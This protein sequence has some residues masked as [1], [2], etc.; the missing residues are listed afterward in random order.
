TTFGQYRVLGDRREGGFNVVYAAQTAVGNKR[1][2]KFYRPENRP[3]F[4]RE[5]E[6]LKELQEDEQHQNL[7]CLHYFNEENMVPYVVL[8]FCE[9]SFVEYMDNMRKRF[10]PYKLAPAAMGAAQDIVEALIYI[11]QRDIVHCDVKGGNILGQ[12]MKGLGHTWKL[13]DFDSARTVNEPVERTTYCPPEVANNILSGRRVLPGASEK[14]D[15]FGLGCT[16]VESITGNRIVD[17]TSEDGLRKLIDPT[18]D[19]EAIV[20]RSL[21]SPVKRLLRKDS[22]NRVSVAE[23]KALLNRDINSQDLLRAFED[24]QKEAKGQMQSAIDA[25]LNGVNALNIDVSSLKRELGDIRNHVFAVRATVDT[26]RLFVII[27]AETTF[28]ITKI[29]GKKY[30]LHLMC[31]H[32]QHHIADLETGGYEIVDLHR[33]VS[34]ARPWLPYVTMCMRLLTAALPAAGVIPTEISKQVKTVLDHSAQAVED[35]QLMLAKYGDE[36]EVLGTDGKEHRLD[37]GPALRM[38]TAFLTQNDSSKKFDGLIPCDVGGGDVRWM[39]SAHATLYNR[40]GSHFD[41]SIPNSNQHNHQHFPS[42]P[43]TPPSPPPKTSFAPSLSHLIQR[44]LSDVLN[45][46]TNAAK[47]FPSGSSRWHV[48]FALG[49]RGIPSAKERSVRER[50]SIP[51]HENVLL[52]YN[53]PVVVMRYRDN[54]AFGQDKL[55]WF[56]RYAS[57]ALDYKD[58]AQV[59][60]NINRPFLLAS[61]GRAALRCSHP[62]A[63]L[64]LLNAVEEIVLK[65]VNNKTGKKTDNASPDKPNEPASAPRTENNA[66]RPPMPPPKH[67]KPSFS[68]PPRSGSLGAMENT[69]DNRISVGI[70]IDLGTS[71]SFL[72][73]GKT[74]V[75]DE[76]QRYTSRNPQNTIFGVKRLFGREFDDVEVQYM[77]R[78]WPFTLVGIDGQP[79]IQIETESGDKHHYK[80]EEISALILL[81]LKRQAEIYLGDGFKVGGAVITVPAYFTDAQRQATKDAASIAGLNVLRMTSEATAASMTYGIHKFLDQVV[82]VVVIDLGG[83]TSDISLI[84]VE[85]NLFEV[86]HTMA[87]MQLGGEDFTDRLVEHCVA[88]FAKKYGTRDIKKSPK[89]MQRL[90]TECRAAQS[91]L[92]AA[93]TAYIQLD[94]LYDGLDLYTTISRQTFETVCQVLFTKIGELLQD[95]ERALK[96]YPVDTDGSE[97]HVVLVGGATRIP[98]IRQMVSDVFGQNVVSLGINPDEAVAIGAA[99]FAAI[100]SGTEDESLCDVL[101]LDVTPFSL[102]V[103]TAGNE[104]AISTLVKQDSSI[105]TK[106][107]ILFTTCT[108]D[109]SE[110]IIPI[111]ELSGRKGSGK[112]GNSFLGCLQLTGLQAA[113]RGVP[114]IEVVFDIDANS[115]LNVTATELSSGKQ[116]AMCVTSD[117]S[118]HVNS[119]RAKSTKMRSSVVEFVGPESKEGEQN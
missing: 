113:P 52:I 4:T 24:G 85:D 44:V 89:A 20:P 36:A 115:I 27:P 49:G 51:K 22:N 17:W 53:G 7:V 92:S 119:N 93:S 10:Q 102:G 43:R 73:N 33:W 9:T 32:N 71:F 39:C 26:P 78:N 69:V 97:P 75:G 42:P 46:K 83:G 114:Q 50:C 12:Y 55:Y 100:L 68:P 41:E 117:E 28:D 76:A 5:V 98:K 107:S 30:K 81:Y 63:L 64:L 96:R 38:L 84:T 59:Q 15:A 31:E 14:M 65:N 105:P 106:K 58:M 91:T 94:G 16:I 11:H 79:F 2:L 108:D 61:N 62:E 48:S 67:S 101:L 90:R 82:D 66:E 60:W 37:V 13:A 95:T 86:R 23:F 25:I 29:I 47:H 99:I 104:P 56:H 6:I 116:V 35:I 112:S 118:R 34:A 74:L 103:E 80:P 21:T 18:F 70:G 88:V 8:D 77:S 109:Q 110:A 45:D 72:E 87:N 1:A 57:G 3:L 19:L 54:I 111:Y 40:S